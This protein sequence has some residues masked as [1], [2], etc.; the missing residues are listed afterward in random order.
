MGAPQNPDHGGVAVWLS[1]CCTADWDLSLNAKIT[2]DANFTW[3]TIDDTQPHDLCREEQ[4]DGALC[5]P[6]SVGSLLLPGRIQ[7]P[8]YYGKYGKIENT[9]PPASLKQAKI[10]RGQTTSLFLDEV[11]FLQHVAKHRPTRPP[12]AAGRQSQAACDR[13]PP[14]AAACRR[15][16]QATI[17]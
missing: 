3:A 11:A 8:P 9:D 4:C 10:L 17:S 5:N 6:W 15:P 16:P 7:M 1:P 14:L 2:I 12:R 13:L